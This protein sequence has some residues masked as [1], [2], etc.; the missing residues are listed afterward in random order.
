MTGW[1]AAD[2][3]VGG[4]RMSSSNAAAGKHISSMNLKSS[5]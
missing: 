2:A 3:K 5:I 1:S 4:R